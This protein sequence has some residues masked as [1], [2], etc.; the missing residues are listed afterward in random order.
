MSHTE[1]DTIAAVATAPG[2]GGIGIIRLSGKEA[3][4]I[5]SEIC[6][7]P[8]SPKIANFSFFQH[9]NDKI[10]EGIAIYFPGPK[11]FTGED[12][13]ELQAHGGPTVLKMLMSAC[14]D[15]GARAA[16]PGEFSERAFLND[17]MDLTQAEAIADLIDAGT[18]AAARAATRSLDGAFSRQINLLQTRLN[19]LRVFVEA[20]IDFPEEEIDFLQD[21]AL[22]KRIEDFQHLLSDTIQEARRGALINE[23]A[24][25]AILGRPNAGKSSLMNLLARKDIAIVTDIAGTT[26][27]SIE[28]QIDIQGVPVTLIDTAG[29]NDAPD[30]IEAIGIERSRTQAENADLLLVLFDSSSL[31]LEPDHKGS[32][33]KLLGDYASILNTNKPV[34]YVANK[35]DLSGLAAGVQEAASDVI[36]LSATTGAGLDALME[37][38]K[39]TLDLGTSEPA[40]SARSR[41]LD[42]LKK[43]QTEL[44]DSVKS[45]GENASGELFAEDLRK[46]QTLL[47]E[48]T[49]AMSADDLLGEIF[50]NFCIG[51]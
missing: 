2:R 18:E 46:V 12:V 20:A 49:G 21:Q 7:K 29:L 42:S 9:Q 8:L 13:V 19:E 31:N 40:F 14:T 45:F 3:L 47:S 26:R 25:I 28:Q 39:T 50:S 10:D 37:T 22:I 24:R 15:L 43:A 1:A 11:S 34:I 35:I 16:R 41:H 48:I 33:E 17:R 23:G 4:R 32:Q 36:G 38:I 6:T 5:G 30:Q 44:N 51:K 27:D